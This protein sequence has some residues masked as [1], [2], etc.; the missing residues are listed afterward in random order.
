MSFPFLE[1]TSVI[2]DWRTLLDLNRISVERF[3][4]CGFGRLFP[5][6]LTML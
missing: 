2:A 4:K 1:G 6:A 3:E 5:L